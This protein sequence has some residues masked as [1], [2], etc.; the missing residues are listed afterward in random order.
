MKVVVHPAAADDLNNAADF[1]T[2]QASKQLGLALITEFE[3]AAL[4]LA[5]NPE[6]STLWRAGTRR[7]ILRRFPFNI[8]YCLFPDH[9]FVIAVAHQRRRPGYW[10]RRQ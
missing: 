9:I 1:Y 10:R 2:S 8:V 6:L 4:L 3:N 7:F 5:E